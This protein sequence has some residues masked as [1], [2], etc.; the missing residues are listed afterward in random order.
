MIL[1]VQP[2]QCTRLICGMCLHKVTYAWWLMN[3]FHCLYSMVSW[4][5]EWTVLDNDHYVAPMSAATHWTQHLG[6]WSVQWSR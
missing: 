5:L 2:L 1:P 6:N 3:H 4:A